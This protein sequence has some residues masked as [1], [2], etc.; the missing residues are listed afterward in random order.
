KAQ[1]AIA[2]GEITHLL[3]AGGDG[4]V[5]IGV[6][7]VADADIPLGI[8]PCGTGNDIA[9]ALGLPIGD[10]KWATQVAIDHLEL[11][12]PVDL[13]KATS[14]I[15]DFYFLG[16]MAAGFDSLVNARANRMKRIKGPIK[17]RIALY[18]ELAKFKKI[19]YKLVV[20]GEIHLLDAML[21]TIANV[22]SYGGGMLIAP[23]AQP[24]DG[25]LDLFIVHKISRPELIKVFPHVYTGTHVEHPAVSIIRVKS[26]ELEAKAPVFADG[27]ASGHPPVKVTVA[28]GKL[29]VLAPTPHGK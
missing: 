1:T 19:S 13:G 16:S 25:E 2:R 20:D 18:L 8:I 22:R 12:R 10:T 21:C 4:M 14:S 17:Y 3:V 26:V 28:P 6:N 11:T 27:E 9:R 29:R 15:G 7:L 24:D 5:N 23:E